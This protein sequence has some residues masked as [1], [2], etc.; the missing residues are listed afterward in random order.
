MENVYD[1]KYKTH[2]RFKKGIREGTLG[3]A[4]DLKDENMINLLVL[5]KGG[6]QWLQRLNVRFLMISKKCGHIYYLI[7][8]YGN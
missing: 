3:Y 4:Y 1:V 8:N 7:S 2:R 5:K 6:Y